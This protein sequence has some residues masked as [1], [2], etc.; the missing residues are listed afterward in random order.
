[1]SERKI[2]YET[3]GGAET[4]IRDRD[5]MP[6]KDDRLEEL[7]KQLAIADRKNAKLLAAA[8]AVDRWDLCGDGLLLND[9]EQYQRD[10]RKLREAIE[11]CDETN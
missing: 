4:T 8:R 2:H 9:K 1:M 3:T 11:A 5:A 6:T 7:S 10:A